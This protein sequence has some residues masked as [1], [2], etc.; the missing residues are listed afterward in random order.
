MSRKKGTPLT[1]RERNGMISL[2]IVSLAT[3]GAGW[4][5]RRCEANRP[6][7][8]GVVVSS[9]TIDSVSL[10]YNKDRNDGSYSRK[11]TSSSRKRHRKAE[12]D[13]TRRG[14]SGHK[15]TK[16]QSAPIPPRHHL[17]E[18]LTEEQ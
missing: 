9:D 15:S 4:F 6:L 13:L 3:I 18:N 17:D 16:K 12:R 7:P 5:V 14:K 1:A 10:Y 2:L 11:S 8:P